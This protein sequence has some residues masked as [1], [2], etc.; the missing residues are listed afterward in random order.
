MDADI[1]LEPP[2]NGLMDDRKYP[3]RIIAKSA[4]WGIRHMMTS[5]GRGSE[6]EA[7]E[8]SVHAS[9]TRMGGEL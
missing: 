4:D 3:S 8:F 5:D 7:E 9:L 2:P 1:G 6:L